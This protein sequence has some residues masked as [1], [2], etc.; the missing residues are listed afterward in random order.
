MS[1]Y[2]VAY[3]TRIR[4]CTSALSLHPQNQYFVFGTFYLRLSAT[5]ADL[6]K[7]DFM[8]RHKITTLL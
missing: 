8:D 4:S 7:G 3:G 2:G 5:W 6:N 1:N